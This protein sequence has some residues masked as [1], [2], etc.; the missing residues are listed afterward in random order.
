MHRSS[1]DTTEYR[2]VSPGKSFSLARSFV[3]DEAK[4]TNEGWVL[5]AGEPFHARAGLWIWAYGLVGLQ[6]YL[7]AENLEAPKLFMEHQK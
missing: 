7:G 6:T 3:G 1:K 4:A 5:E 2:Y